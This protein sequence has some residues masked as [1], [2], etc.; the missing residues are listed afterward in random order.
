MHMINLK[1]AVLIVFTLTGF[2]SEVMVAQSG[3]P[4]DDVWQSI[5][6]TLAQPQGDTNCYA[7]IQEVRKHCQDNYPCLK[8]TYSYVLRELEGRFNHFA[9]V[10]VAKEM[11][12]LAEKNKDIE[13]Q[14]SAL[15]RLVEMYNF[16]N[17]PRM[18]T[19]YSEQLMTLYKQTGNDKK[20]LEMKAYLVEG[21]V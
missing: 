4:S 15:R 3:A 17:H 16:M 13:E 12:D 8:S 2:R 6:T 20:V 21:R 18:F 11:V 5:E 7:I 10:A 9:G 19:Y 14:A 1:R